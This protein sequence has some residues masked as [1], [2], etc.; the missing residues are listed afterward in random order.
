MRH[1]PK[2]S[3]QA[4]GRIVALALLAD[5]HLCKRELDVLD[6]FDAHGQL[7]LTQGALHAVVHGFCEDLLATAN[8]HWDA[9]FQLDA[10]VGGTPAYRPLA[11]DEVPTGGDI[12]TWVQR[13]LLGRGAPLRREGQIVA[14][15]DP[16]LTTGC[17]S[18]PCWPRS[19]MG[20]RLAGP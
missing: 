8:G 3:P 15:E 14:D 12:A 1:Y 18:S 16:A 20:E 11:S 10:F 6:Q 9:A 7:G 13:H 17:S 5:G 4:A 19:R 2:N